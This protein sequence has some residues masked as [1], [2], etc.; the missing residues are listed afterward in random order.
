MFAACNVA[1]HALIKRYGLPKSFELSP[2]YLFF[3]DKIERA[4]FFLHAVW[5]HAGEGADSRV[6]QHLMSTPGDD[7]G[8][9]DMLVAVIEKH[10]VMPKACFP[11]MTHSKSSGT[12]NGMLKMKLREFSSA[13]V[14]A[15]ADGATD[16]EA[17]GMIGGMMGVVHRIVASC[18]GPVPATVEFEY[19]PAG[20]GACAKLCSVSGL[21]PLEFYTSVVKPVF[22]FSQYVSLVHD[23]RPE[24]PVGSV[25]T[26]ACLG[27]VVGSK[28][29]VRYLNATVATLKRLVIDS[30]LDDEP[31]W[32]G[33]DVGKSLLRDR[34]VLSIGNYD[35]GGVFG[36]CQCM[37][38][39]TRMRFKHSMMVR[40]IACQN[41]C[42]DSIGPSA[43]RSCPF[44]TP[45]PCMRRPTQ[46]CLLV[47]ICLQPRRLWWSCWRRQ[48]RPNRLTR[49]LPQRIP[50]RNQPPRPSWAT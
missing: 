13:L 23:P 46:W 2:A 43:P 15:K 42:G 9:W 16:E 25:M 3:W 7:G 21:S 49:P 11:D 27:S 34:G 4:N 18:F 31:V 48:R 14:G 47:S 17:A 32:F 20:K 24:H 45:V 1:R 5:A 37:S 40:H 26:V 36:A 28:H 50:R 19:K 10:G 8:Q 29:A 22:D 33:C 39:E 12:M 6:I 38:K 30:I 44:T 35:F 41:G